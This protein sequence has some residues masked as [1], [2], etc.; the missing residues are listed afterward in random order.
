MKNIKNLFIISLFLGILVAGGGFAY[1]VQAAGLTQS[2][3]NAIISLLQSFG[4]DQATI[5]NVQT[6]LSGTPTTPPPT[7][8]CHDFNVNLKIGDKGVEVNDLKVALQ[9]EGFDVSVNFVD[10]A[11]ASFNEKIASAVT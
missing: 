10:A 2:Q 11:N 9:K 1:Q 5:N 6:A 8:W 3:V 7:A 4:A